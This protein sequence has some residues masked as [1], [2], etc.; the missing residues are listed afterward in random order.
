MK[1]KLM[2]FILIFLLAMAGIIVTSISGGSNA[3][4]ISLAVV[5]L[6]VMG[7]ILVSWLNYIKKIS[8]QSS[9][10]LG[11]TTDMP[12]KWSFGHQDQI[13]S[14]HERIKEKFQISAEMISNLAQDEQDSDH[15]SD[16]LNDDPIGEALQNIRKEMR[17]LKEEEQKQTWINKGLARFSEIL[18]NKTE[19][20]DYSHQIISNLVKYV[21]ANQG[22]LFIEY[23]DES[24]ESFLEL[25]ACYA[26]DKRKYIDKKIYK[27]Q[28]LLGQ[29]MHEKDFIFITDVPKDYVKITSGLGEATPCNVIVAPLIFN[30]KFYGAIELALFEV[31]EPHRFDFL[32]KVCDN[33]ASEIA[34]IKNIQHTENLLSESNVLAQ[35]LQANEEEM[36]QNLEELAA[37]QE[38]MDR[39]QA[40]LSGVLSA[41]DTTLATAEFDMD[42][43][44]K[45][46]NDIFLTL[47]HFKKE[48]IVDKEYQFFM[49][50]DQRIVMMWENL[51]L[52]K[53]FSGEFKMKDKTGQV[54]WLSGTFNPIMIKGDVPQK[55]MMFAQFTTQ[56]KE[57]TNSLNTMVNAVKSTIP[58]MEF[59]SNMQC[60]S[61]NK[62]FLELFGL[63]RMDLKSKSITDFIDSSNWVGHYKELMETGFM[64][65]KLPMLLDSHR[66]IFEVSFTVTKN[67]E[68]EVS[69]I[70]LL[71]VKEIE[72]EA[73][74]FMSSQQ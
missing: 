56:E 43:N 7:L 33:I 63:S 72:E 49:G 42:G 29:C 70:I 68:G 3:M 9:Q 31:M 46:A 23:S 2:F 36:K 28:G 67:L 21:E 22:A 65:F 37:T 12:S 71:L 66:P 59:D 4:I 5:G 41:I 45:S 17:M 14:N 35:E 6:I 53:F 24:D 64:N 38:E 61:G 60:K 1:K 55:V 54:L 26:Y 27:G 19:V 32:K 48:D 40:E 47:M 58:V 15:Q 39:K 8:I 18:R 51:R 34:S 52:G 30:D 50:N 16:L 13:I 57:K 11:A 25:A 62:L 73:E 69:R 44:I 20:K 74:V 10:A